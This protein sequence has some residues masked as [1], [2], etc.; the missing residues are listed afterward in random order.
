M[1]DILAEVRTWGFPV[2]R[3]ERGTVSL[4]WTEFVLTAATKL[5]VKP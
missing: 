4:L 2:R 5:G 3:L 1:A